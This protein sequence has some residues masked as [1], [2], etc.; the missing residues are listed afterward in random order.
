M[1]EEKITYYI[2]K[3]NN[4]QKAIEL[5]NEKIFQYENMLL[6]EKR[7]QEDRGFFTR[8][9][10]KNKFISSI[11]K[12][13]KEHHKES[14]N[15]DY[16]LKTEIQDFINIG[17][18]E[19]ENNKKENSNDNLHECLIKE[20]QY[21]SNF[22]TIINECESN[23]YAAMDNLKKIIY[24]SGYSTNERC[25]YV[26]DLLKSNILKIKS[27]SELIIEYKL[28]SKDIESIKHSMNSILSCESEL[29]KVTKYKDI[30]TLNLSFKDMEI[31]LKFLKTTFSILDEKAKNKLNE[32][33]EKTD[34]HLSDYKILF[35]NKLRNEHNLDLSK[36]Q[37]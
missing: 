34:N 13:L 6:E 25:K 1:L 3:I 19:I 22:I 4:I 37:I 7:K 20:M 32:F 9:F 29:D 33:E 16:L 15:L 11:E 30:K 21:I 31:N 2:S 17:V 26:C 14:D 10:I 18:N 5:E 28:F 12:I 35:L 27:C 8:L 24:S 23:Y 36:Y